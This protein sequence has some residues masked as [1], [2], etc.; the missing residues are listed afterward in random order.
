MLK[1]K[2]SSCKKKKSLDRLIHLA[3]QQDLIAFAKIKFQRRK[4]NTQSHPHPQTHSTRHTNTYTLWGSDV[5]TRQEVLS[6][7]ETD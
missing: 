1:C 7:V 3:T 2:Y 6:Y 5:Q 4:S